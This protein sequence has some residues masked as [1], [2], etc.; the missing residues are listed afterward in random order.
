MNTTGIVA[1]SDL[2]EYGK[3][4][5]ALGLLASQL[6]RSTRATKEKMAEM[7]AAVAMSISLRKRCLASKIPALVMISK[8]DKSF[9]E[10]LITKSDVW[11]YVQWM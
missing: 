3:L 7:F 6:S 2:N 10:Y 11:E 4:D 8:D 9:H 1:I 5:T